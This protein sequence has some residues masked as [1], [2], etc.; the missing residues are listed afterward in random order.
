[1][2]ALCQQRTPVS[3]GAGPGLFVIEV[4]RAVP[5]GG[6]RIVLEALNAGEEDHARSVFGCYRQGRFQGASRLIPAARPIGGEPLRIVRAQRNLFRRQLACSSHDVKNDLRLG[7]AEDD[8]AIDFACFDRRRWPPQP[9]PLPP[10]I[11]CR[12]IC[13]RTRAARRG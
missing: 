7:L 13:W 8:H 1:M 4:P 2:S 10:D 6:R 3:V 11:G 9:S 5:I 12:K